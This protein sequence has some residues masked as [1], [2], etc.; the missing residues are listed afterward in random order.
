MRTYKWGWEDDSWPRF[1][2]EVPD[3][4]ELAIANTEYEVTEFSAAQ[5]RVARIVT[6]KLIFIDP[7]EDMDEAQGQL[8][9][10]PGA[11]KLIDKEKT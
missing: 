11:L 3:G 5:L 2:V 7:Q 6:V 8:S 4:S 1:S 10:A 9:F